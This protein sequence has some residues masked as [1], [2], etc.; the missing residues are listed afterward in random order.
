MPKQSHEIAQESRD[1]E[2][3]ILGGRS[4]RAV[5]NGREYT[6]LKP[7]RRDNRIM[8]A[9]VV[10]IQQIAQRTENRVRVLMEMFQFLIDWHPMIA[11]DEIA[12]EDAMRAELSTGSAKTSTEIAQ[13]Y[14]EFALLVSVPFRPAASTQKT[15]KD[16]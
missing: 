3:E 7:S 11:A 4:R 15:E 10:K 16:T 12:I 5:I 1:N 9:E 14:K 8:F 6:F 13:A 2:A